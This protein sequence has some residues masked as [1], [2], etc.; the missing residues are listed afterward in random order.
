[1]TQAVNKVTMQTNQKISSDKNQTEGF[2][3]NDGL[4]KRGAGARKV[5]GA[6]IQCFKAKQSLKKF[7]AI[8]EANF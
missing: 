6:T 2:T 1:M 3:K 4:T 8:G 7:I 5:R